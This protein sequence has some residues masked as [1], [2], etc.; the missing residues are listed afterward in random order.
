MEIQKILVPLDGSMLAE[1]A[2]DTAIHLA[3]GAPSPSRS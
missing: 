2:I 1:A 3:A